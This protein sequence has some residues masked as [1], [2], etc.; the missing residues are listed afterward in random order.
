MIKR[1]VTIEENE[2]NKSILE[3]ELC[4]NIQRI[5]IR[6]IVKKYIYFNDTCVMFLLKT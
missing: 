3:F 1:Y 6:K 2:E 4:T 5:E